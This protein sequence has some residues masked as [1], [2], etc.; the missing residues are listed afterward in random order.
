MIKPGSNDKISFVYS[1]EP[2]AFCGNKDCK[3]HLETMD[4]EDAE[5]VCDYCRH[6]MIILPGEDGGN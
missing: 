3:R 5:Q 2:V 1:D 6:I 4:P